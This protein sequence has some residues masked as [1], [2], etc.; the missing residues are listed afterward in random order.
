[1]GPCGGTTCV[2][3]GT[4]G[5]T[6]I[7]LRGGGSCGCVAMDVGSGVVVGGRGR[8][9]FTALEKPRVRGGFGHRKN[10]PHVPLRGAWF[11]CDFSRGCS[12]GS[13]AGLWPVPGARGPGP[14]TPR[15]LDRPLVASEAA[16][17]PRRTPGHCLRA[18]ISQ[19]PGATGHNENK[20]LPFPHHGNAPQHGEAPAAF[21]HPSG[22]FWGPVLPP[23]RPRIGHGD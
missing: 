1:M 2:V 23:R 18:P 12:F 13:K 19:C 4:T 22:G 16:P 20:A 3:P 15:R 11:G 6:Q 5:C 9:D 7:S 21:G 14:P 8:G 10:V 17:G